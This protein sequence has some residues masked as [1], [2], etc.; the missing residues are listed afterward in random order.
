M[1]YLLILLLV[2]A[3]ADEETTFAHNWKWDSTP[4]VVTPDPDVEF[5]RELALA[6]KGW[7]RAAGCPIFAVGAD[8]PVTIELA[9]PHESLRGTSW[10][11]LVGGTPVQGWIKLHGVAQTQVAYV[12]LLHELGRILGLGDDRTQRHSAMHPN[13]AEMDPL[14]GPG[15][16]ITSKDGDAVGKR[17]CHR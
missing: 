1:R 13:I 16:R 14:D 11:R 10:I 17:Y 3:C 7:N 12:V 6:V 8:G 4:I 15:V 5:D 2:A 9:N